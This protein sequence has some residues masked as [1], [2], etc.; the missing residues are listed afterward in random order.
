MHW[1]LR[2]IV[3]AAALWAIAN[4][5]PGFEHPTLLQ[6]LLGA[7]IFG[8]VN[9]FIG[10]ILRLI[11]LPF[12]IITIGLFSIVVNWALFALTSRFAP[13][14]H[15]TGVEWSPW[16]STLV[17]AV[18]MTVITTFVTTPLGESASSND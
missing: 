6:A 14:L 15:T 5:V 18:I 2:F 12:T 1:L 13:G 9:T 10:P 8:L 16:L 4:Y 3:T 17:G 7:V 11:S